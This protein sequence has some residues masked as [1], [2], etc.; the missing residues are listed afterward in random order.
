MFESPRTFPLPRLAAFLV[1]AV[2]ATSCSDEPTRTSADGPGGT[3][4]SP[5]LEAL[6]PLVARAVGEALAAVRGAPDNAATWRTLALTADAN[7]LFPLARASYEALVTL[8]PDA[9]D[10]WAHLARVQ[11]E[12]GNK[13][14][15]DEALA[16][17][18]AL[19]DDHAPSHARRGNWHLEDGDLAL[20]AASFRRAIDVDATLAAG[21]IGLARTALQSDDLDTADAT[22]TTWLAR[23]PDDL[24]ATWLL[25]TLRRKQGRADEAAALLARGAGAQ[26]AWRD[27]WMDDVAAHLVGY[28][29]IMDRAVALGQQGRGAEALES[30]TFLAEARPDDLA[31]LEKLVGALLDADNHAGALARLA[32]AGTRFPDHPRVDF[33]RGLALEQAGQLDDAHAAV[34]RSVAGHAWPPALALLARLHWRLGDIPGAATHLERLI[35]L[36]PD[37]LASRVKLARAYVLTERADEAAAVL[38][39]ALEQFPASPDMLAQRA[40]LAMNAGDRTLAWTLIGRALADPAATP[41]VARTLAGLRAA[42]PDGVPLAPSPT[43]DR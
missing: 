33:L 11:H 21:W 25:G 14:A 30:L 9:A 32:D 29:A 10:A 39:G 4:P 1:A 7:A 17:S 3:I 36:D 23:R 40:E 27:P 6:D 18:L 12:L 42:D 38:D 8:A 35:E 22:L 15:A 20:A 34:T 24:Y 2:V 28:N 31:V 41:L 16:H 5:D 19:A 26:P 13:A 43:D 37:D